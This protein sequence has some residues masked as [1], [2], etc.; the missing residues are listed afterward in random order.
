MSSVHQ[1]LGV[2][3]V[4]VVAAGAVWALVGAIRGNVSATLRTFV[5]LCV[6][7]LFVQVLL[8][9][10]LLA[11]G[12]RPADGLHF[13][14]GG[15]VLLSVPGGIAYA[16]KGDVRREAWGMCFGLIAAV[17]LAA[18]AVATGG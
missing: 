7:A 1:R 13:L 17:L 12:H 15:L 8:G 6:A 5:R 9:L 10:L 14:Y 16:G 11:T 3:L 2:A 4:V 18:R